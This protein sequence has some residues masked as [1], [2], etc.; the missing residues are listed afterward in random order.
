MTTIVLPSS[1]QLREFL[2]RAKYPI[3]LLALTITA[4][5]LQGGTYKDICGAAGVSHSGGRA[6]VL[7]AMRKLRRLLPKEERGKLPYAAYI[8]IWRGTEAAAG[9]SELVHAAID[10]YPE[11]MP[12]RKRRHDSVR[13]T[14]DLKSPRLIDYNNLDKPL[15]ARELDPEH[16]YFAEVRS[17]MTASSTNQ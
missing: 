2:L 5:V 1:Q 17:T 6:M 3:E 4:E 11:T 15:K 7:S 13:F 10:S 9:W 12:V 14:V 16:C 8:L